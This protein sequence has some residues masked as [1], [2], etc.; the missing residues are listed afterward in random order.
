MWPFASGTHE[1]EALKATIRR[2]TQQRDYH[3]GR[4][5]TALGVAHRIAA[6]FSD[7]HD[8]CW[9]EN[10]RLREQV[11]GHQNLLRRHAR[12][13]S[14]CARYRA[15]VAKL[16]SELESKSWYR[17]LADL[18][19][20]LNA[21]EN[22]LAQLREQNEKQDRELAERSGAYANQAAA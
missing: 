19:A 22:D 11:D 2:R 12:L 5:D 6:K 15:E 7:N 10:A 20:L 1:T 16:R 13:L 14:A 17:E 18:K 4:A 8:L 9:D 3:H 21:K